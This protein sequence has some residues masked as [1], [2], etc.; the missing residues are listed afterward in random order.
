MK[1]KSSKRSNSGFLISF[2]GGEGGGKSTQIR[3]L[4][5][6]FTDHNIPVVLTLEPGGTKIGSKIRKILLDPK[7]TEI[8]HRAEL[9]LYLADR[10]QHVEECILPALKAGKVVISD[11]YA[12]SSN[13]YQG[14]CR[15]LGL[16]WTMALNDYA[17]DGLYPNIAIILDIPEKIGLARVQQRILTQK[18]NHKSSSAQ[19]DRM[20][21]EK[22]AFHKKVRQGFLLLSKKY[23]KRI[24]VINAALSE[25][26]VKAAIQKL[27]RNRIQ[28]MK[29]HSLWKKLE[30]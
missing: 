18:F 9:L 19:L 17:T 15:K 8:S 6:Y 4:V 14:I 13:V 20:E 5:K 25:K 28:K 7:N 10:A 11:R 2:E 1:L 3:H 23:P 26:E 22:I 27:I 12:D 16:E 30:Q 29:G 21:N 24:Q